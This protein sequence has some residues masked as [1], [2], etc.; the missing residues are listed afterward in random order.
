MS[1]WFSAVLVLE[2]E[3]NGLVPED[4]LCEAS[5]RLI[6]SSDADDAYEKAAVLGLEA[7]HGYLNENNERV[8]W[9]FRR[10]AEIQDLGSIVPSNGVEVFSRMFRKGETQDI[11]PF[12]GE[13]ASR[14]KV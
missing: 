6:E 13:L 8:E 14:G 11:L 1:G 4:G 2:A 3:V 9:R 12:L 7:E 10:V 5:V